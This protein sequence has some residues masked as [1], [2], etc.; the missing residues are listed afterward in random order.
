VE[1]FIDRSAEI[2]QTHQIWAG[3]LVGLMAFGESLVVVGILLP[4]TAVLVIVGGL[5]G[6][7]VIEPVPVLIGAVVGAAIGDTVSYALGT[8][9]GRGIISKWPLNQYR[10]T[11][12]RARLF[13]RRYGLAA[14]FVG[15]FFG[16]VRS[17]VPFVA[18]M[19]RMDWRHFQI[20]NILSGLLWAPVVLSPGWLVAKGAGSLIE[21]SEADWFG[22]AAVVAV[23]TIVAA[24]II[25]KI[26]RRSRERGL[27]RA[28]RRRLP[29]E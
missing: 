5:I 16:P 23:L 10:E 14:V 9:L 19:M 8:W 6:A 28:M 11:L 27:I 21:M 1:Q 20:A 3:P 13:F 12:A 22:V 7:G 25:A 4:G 18:G 24:G 26:T 17:A 2:I 15:R 29:A